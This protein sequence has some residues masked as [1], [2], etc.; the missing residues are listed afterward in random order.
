MENTTPIIP[1]G[2]RLKSTPTKDNSWLYSP[3]PVNIILHGKQYDSVKD[4]NQ[5]Q[6]HIS[7]Q[8]EGRGRFHRYE[9]KTPQKKETHKPRN[10][11]VLISWTRQG[12]HSPPRTSEALGPADILILSKRHWLW[13]CS[14][15]KWKGTNASY[16]KPPSLWLR[17]RIHS[18]TAALLSLNGDAPRR[19]SIPTVASWPR[20][21][22][23][24]P[25]K[26]RCKLHRAGLPN[27]PCWL[28]YIHTWVPWPLGVTWETVAPVTL[29]LWKRSP[30]SK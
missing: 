20:S 26:A 9:E 2:G 6:S 13:T 28:K 10:A 1:H 12:A 11:A 15:R 17:T 24:G 5:M 4:L 8:N 29:F 23:Q 19:L 21:Q 30:D 27:M 22:L 14:L 18:V 7:Q 25:G 16:F 3:A